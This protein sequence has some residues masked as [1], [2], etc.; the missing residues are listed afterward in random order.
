[1][2]NGA[3][4]G[5]FDYNGGDPST[6]G[7]RWELWLAKWKLY[8][9]AEA[10]TD[11][12]IMKA[13]FLLLIGDEVFKVYEGLRAV[14]SKDEMD[15]IYEFLNKA[16]IIKRSAFAQSQIFR[17]TMRRKDES[18]QEYSGRL[19]ELAKHCNFK[20]ESEQILGQ[21]V[22]GCQMPE[23]QEECC[24]TDDLTL[25]K[26]LELARG[27]ERSKFDMSS[28]LQQDERVHAIASSNNFMGAKLSNH[29]NN[30]LFRQSAANCGNCGHLRHENSQTCPAKNA[31][32][33]LCDRQ[34]HYAAVCRSSNKQN[35][36][37]RQQQQQ[38]HQ[39][40]NK[41][42]GGKKSFNHIQ[43][44]PSTS[45]GQGIRDDEYDEFMR[46]KRAKQWDLLKIDTAVSSSDDSARVVVDVDGSSMDLLIDT[47][48][49]VNVCNE[50]AYNKL[51]SRPHL[52][53][54]NTRYFGYKSKSPLDVLGTFEAMVSFNNR[55]C[56]AY[57]LVVKG[58]G[59]CLLS[60]RTSIKLGIV[61][62]CN[63]IIKEPEC[64][65]RAAD[66]ATRFP[67]LFSGK[68]G[69]MKGEPVKL[70]VDPT[71]R[72]VRQPQRPI[73]F[74]L[75]EPV[76]RELR[77][78][79]ENDILE[80]VTDDMGPIE[81]QSNLVVVPQG[82]DCSAKCGPGR[83]TA[84]EEQWSG[85]IRLTCDS[86]QLNKAI[87]RTRYP[88]KSVED[89]VCMVNGSKVFSKLDISKAFHQLNLDESSRNYTTITTHIGLFRYKRLHQ[90]VSCA[91]KLS[92]SVFEWC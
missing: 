74:H 91:S 88:G 50:E 32:C 11:K 30:N 72:P 7:Q 53:T 54:T 83:M 28:L 56:K 26:A 36:N 67:S 25:T 48:A 22:I 46:Y 49:P 21:F 12:V 58:Y 87:R 29:A 82:K 62:I 86:K 66:F 15:T 85:D 41:P 47:G 61:L 71:V 23:F 42:F 24:R 16:L 89:L 38:H 68:I 81:W 27:Y 92:P 8:L 84:T 35:Q 52:N 51:S 39:N 45:G 37:K 20:D 2:N 77:K 78:Q 76:E 17:G 31:K 70:E 73:A 34:G 1:M 65:P 10:L 79:L 19:R 60:F 4:C 90:G 63:S 3:T 69:C 6:L 44:K 55:S 43:P 57:F 59:E 5:R 9:A 64:D 40:P 13:K 33:R 80:R 14:D 18:V 75:R